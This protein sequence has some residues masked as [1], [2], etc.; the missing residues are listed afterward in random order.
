[1][2]RRCSPTEWAAA[3]WRKRV[4]VCD[5]GRRVARRCVPMPG[6]HSAGR[7]VYIV[8]LLHPK[9]ACAVVHCSS[10]ASP[11]LQVRIVQS[12]AKK[13]M[14]CGASS[15]TSFVCA[16]HSTAASHRRRHTRQNTI[17]R[18]A[19][20]L[21]LGRSGRVGA[22][23]GFERL[24]AAADGSLGVARPQRQQLRH[25]QWSVEHERTWGG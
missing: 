9:C 20:L 23:R 6:F 24:A 3:N 19:M 21:L 16:L 2:C 18:Q 11:G 13:N 17:D 15:T 7:S 14:W 4:R 1:M 10:L 8:C 22:R 12:S 25:K 5:S